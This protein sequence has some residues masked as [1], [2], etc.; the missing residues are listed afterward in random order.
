MFA[1]YPLLL[2]TLNT[3]YTFNRSTE[4]P[5][6]HCGNWYLRS[7]SRASLPP[8]DFFSS[9][10]ASISHPSFLTLDPDT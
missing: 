8:S 9:T 6:L 1:V 4:A 5:R 3:P 2:Y 10:G 7:I